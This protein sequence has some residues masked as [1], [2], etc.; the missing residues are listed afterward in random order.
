MEKKKDRV[1]T[2]WWNT[3][4]FVLFFV[5]K[6]KIKLPV[7]CELFDRVTGWPILS[8]LTNW[9]NVHWIKCRGRTTQKKKWRRNE[10]SERK[11]SL[12]MINRE[13][14]MWFSSS[15]LLFKKA[16]PNCDNFYWANETKGGETKCEIKFKEN[17]LFSF[18]CIS[19]DKLNA[20]CIT[21]ACQIVINK[22]KT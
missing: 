22:N 12:W 8:P 7:I 17:N 6:V 13:M 15:F 2:K 10:Q 4:E 16:S 18:L 20:N 14:R 1:K 19:C 11:K 21:F 3:K 5:Y 9:I